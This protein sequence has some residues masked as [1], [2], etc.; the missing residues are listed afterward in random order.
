MAEI[1]AGRICS[2]IQIKK[3]RLIGKQGEDNLGRTVIVE[4]TASQVGGVLTA[5]FPLY[6]VRITVKKTIL[7]KWVGLN[8]NTDE[9]ENLTP[10]KP[11]LDEL[12]SK[13]EADTRNMAE[14][15]KICQLDIKYHMHGDFFYDA[16]DTNRDPLA[17][18]KPKGIDY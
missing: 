14:A 5:Y 10:A 15:E 1:A 7:A 8:L 17:Y 2:L 12:Y 11:T 6:G 13:L 9:E 4:D 16:M 3:E 18:E